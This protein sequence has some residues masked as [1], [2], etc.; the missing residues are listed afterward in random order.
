MDLKFSAMVLA[1]GFG[2]RMMPLTRDIPKP[3]LNI[4]G[5]SLLDNSINFLKK[6]GCNQVVVN[7]HYKNTQIESSIGKRKDRDD[8]DLIHEKEILDTAGAVKNAIN[9]FKNENIIR[10]K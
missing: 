4:N 10:Q 9:L 5:I 6:L 3:L 8:I 1:A 7:T 2:K